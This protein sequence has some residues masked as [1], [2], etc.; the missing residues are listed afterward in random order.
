MV[1]CRDVG[2]GFD[3][4]R[5]IAATVLPPAASG[6]G[7]S[8][9]SA[10]LRARAV[11]LA[12]NA[13]VDLLLASQLRAHGI[14]PPAE[15]AARAA[16][17]KAAAAWSWVEGAAI[18]DA[19]DRAGFAPIVLKGGD[20]SA[21]AYP[22]VFA[23]LPDRAYLRHATDLDLLLALP[24]T[25]APVMRKEGFVPDVQGAAHHVRW[26]KEGPGLSFSVELHGDLFDRPH[27]L[28][29]SLAAMRESSVT[30]TSPDGGSRRV[31]A[32]VDAFLHLAGHAVYSD[33]LRDP[34]SALRGPI[35]LAVLARATPVQSTLLLRTAVDAGLAA[36]VGIA[37]HWSELLGTGLP[38][39]LASIGRAMFARGGVRFAFGKRRLLLNAQVAV[40]GG[41][42]P[43]G[44][45]TAW[46]AL[47]A[48]SLGSAASMLVE[49][50]RRRSG[51]KGP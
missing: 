16:Q 20:L 51:M 19:L 41:P 10:E 22:V 49:G 12:G 2:L 47:L 4:A 34:V 30:V 37:T 14:E 50:L 44:P 40:E 6:A 32:P 29:H 11:A 43:A 31:L 35:D 23:A 33:L 24:D 28:R 1:A 38:A 7:W 5:L 9:A 15:L 42:F 46:R 45:A 13:R 39:E 8:A 26:R 3:A 25:A 21:R 36:A 18:V 48:P 17:A 27:G